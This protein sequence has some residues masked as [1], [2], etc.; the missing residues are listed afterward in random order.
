MFAYQLVHILSLYHTIG[1]FVFFLTF[2]CKIIFTVVLITFIVL[3]SNETELFFYVMAYYIPY[4]QAVS[5]CFP[6]VKIF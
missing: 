5:L 3:I 2:G 1:F 4:V 6:T